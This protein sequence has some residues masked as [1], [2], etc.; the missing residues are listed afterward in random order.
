VHDRRT[1]SGTALPDVDVERT[2]SGT[3][4]FRD[5]SSGVPEMRTIVIAA[6]ATLATAGASTP[7]RAATAASS[8]P[9]LCRTTPAEEVRPAGRWAGGCASGVAD[10]HG[11]MRVSGPGGAGVFSGLARRGRPVAGV[12][13]LDDGTLRTLAPPVRRASRYL[14]AAAAADDRAYDAAYAGALAASAAYAAAGNAP[15]A[16]WY[17]EFRRRLERERPE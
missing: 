15:S 10:G 11:A 4:R 2:S 8:P 14:D 1:A 12:T 9:S 16:R 5:E 3:V 7:M 6:A 17:L 13:V